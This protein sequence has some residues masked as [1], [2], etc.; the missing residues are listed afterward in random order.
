MQMECG[1]AYSSGKS[2]RVRGVLNLTRLRL[3]IFNLCARCWVRWAR[4]LCHA[5]AAFATDVGEQISRCTL[6]DLPL[7][8]H[9]PSPN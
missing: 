1:R 8:V 9:R 5:L 4:L 3:L 6:S 2:P 7:V